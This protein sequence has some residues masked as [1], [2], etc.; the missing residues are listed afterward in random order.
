VGKKADK[1][2]KYVKEKVGA[3]YSKARAILN[4][5]GPTASVQYSAPTGMF[6]EKFRTVMMKHTGYDYKAKSFN[7]SLYGTWP[8][9]YS[10]GTSMLNDAVDRHFRFAMK[11]TK[12]KLH[13]WAAEVLAMLK[14]Y[15]NSKV[16]PRGPA[17]GFYR[18]YN[19]TTAGY[20]IGATNPNDMYS[21]DYMDDYIKVKAGAIIYDTV[22]P[23]SWKRRAN[24]WFPKDI[25]PF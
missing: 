7:P 3:L 21:L 6:S 19:K 2:K 12:G 13:A 23:K 1:A 11:R 20:D 9:Y 18:A 14:G 25:N 22:V 24:S 16:D 17:W 10:W 15:D 8:T 5:A 4:L